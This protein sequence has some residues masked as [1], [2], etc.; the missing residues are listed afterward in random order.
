MPEGVL[1]EEYALEH[2]AG[3]LHCARGA[4]VT[5][6]WLLLH[7]RARLRKLPVPDA[8]YERREAEALLLVV[9]RLHLTCRTEGARTGRGTRTQ[10][11]SQRAGGP[12]IEDG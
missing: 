12:A 5:I 4:N 1:S 2:T 11:R 3:L 8:D 6:R 9:I 7:R 10:R